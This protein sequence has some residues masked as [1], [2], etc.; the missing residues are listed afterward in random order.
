MDTSC[1]IDN[2]I[3]IGGRRSK[4]NKID[5]IATMLRLVFLVTAQPDVEGICAGDRG[6]RLARR[7]Y[8]AIC[9]LS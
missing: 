3:E 7:L 5:S 2:D 9:L 1:L 4:V 8:L 6:L